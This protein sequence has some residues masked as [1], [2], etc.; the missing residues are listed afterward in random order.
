MS[1]LLGHSCHLESSTEGWNKMHIASSL[2]SRLLVA[3]TRCLPGA[4]MA[5]CL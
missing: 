1:G 3:C 2:G 5:Q 4:G